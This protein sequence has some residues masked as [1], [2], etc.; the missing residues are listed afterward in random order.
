MKKIGFPV[1]FLALFA[2]AAPLPTY[3]I[4]TVVNRNGKPEKM[5]LILEANKPGSISAVDT[6]TG[7]GLKIEVQAEPVDS[8]TVLLNYTVK[9][10]LKG[11][12]KIIGTPQ[13][14]VFLDQ[15]AKMEIGNSSSKS[16]GLDVTVTEKK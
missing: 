4:D 16:L 7:A 12:E 2:A 14:M 1:L 15:K 9:E 10:I 3:Q 5:A 8:E 11:E 6:K 13:I